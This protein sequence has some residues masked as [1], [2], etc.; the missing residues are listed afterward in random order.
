MSKKS[1]VE[2]VA[3]ILKKGKLNNNG[4]FRNK[5]WLMTNNKQYLS[6]YCTI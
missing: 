2:V 5:L 3:D 1:K 6:R 4:L